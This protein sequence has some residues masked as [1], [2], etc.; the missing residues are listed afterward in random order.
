MVDKR[1]EGRSEPLFIATQT[2]IHLGASCCEHGGRC[3]LLHIW[4][5]LR[6]DGCNIW[7][8][9]LRIVFET[10]VAKKINQRV[11]GYLL[12]RFGC[13]SFCRDFSCFAAW[14]SFGKRLRYL[15]IISY[16]RSSADQ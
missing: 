4:W 2:S 10:R 3:I 14:H 6:R 7:R 5:K 8:Y 12:K 16:S 15:R 13:F 11:C 9:L 1:N